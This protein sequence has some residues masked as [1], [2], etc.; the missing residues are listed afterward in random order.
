MNQDNVQTAI[1]TLQAYFY[2]KHPTLEDVD[3]FANDVLKILFSRDEVFEAIRQY[4]INCGITMDPG[5]LLTIKHQ[6]DDWYEEYKNESSHSFEYSKRYEQYLK[7]VKKLSESVIKSTIKNNELTIKNF[8]DP[9]STDIVSRKGLVV[10]DVQ[11]GKTLN[12]IGLINRAVDCGYKNIIL[13]TGTT[14]E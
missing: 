4:K 11:A 10:G 1:S 2:G 14:E 9:N 12:Y 13:L 7:I 6:D 8:A 5:E 3:K